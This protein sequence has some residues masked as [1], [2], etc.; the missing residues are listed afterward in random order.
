MSDNPPPTIGRVVT[1][2]NCPPNL[3]LASDKLWDANGMPSLDVLKDWF[4]KEGRLSTEDATKICEL[5]T[6]VLKEEPNV[7]TINAAVT[8]CGDIHG[9]FYDLVKLF[10]VGGSPSETTYIFLGDYVDRGQFGLEC[11]LFLLSHKIRYPKN[12]FLLRGN[13]ECRHLTAF[14]NFKEECLYKFNEDLYD[15]IMNAFD[16]LPL[17]A[18]VNQKFFCCHGGLSPE[19]HSVDQI[20]E[21]NR[22]CE[23]PNSGAMC[24]ILW[25]DPLDD[26]AEDTTFLPNS[27]RGCSVFFGVAAVARFL[28]ENNLLSV[29]RAHE[30]QLDGFKMH[31]KRHPNDFPSVI[32]LFSAPNY[33]DTYA[34]KGAI[35]KYHENT[36]KIRQFN[37]TP[38]PYYLPNFMNVFEWSLPFVADKI[39]EFCVAILN[40]TPDE[41]E[42]VP[43]AAEQREISA[44]VIKNKIRSAAKFAVMLRA[45]RDHSDEI[46]QIK[47]EMPDN[48][49]P[50]GLLQ[51]GTAEI[52]KVLESFNRAKLA[53]VNNE[54]LPS[55]EELKAHMAPRTRKASLGPDQAEKHRQQMQMAEEALANDSTK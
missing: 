25:A 27:T 7:L 23:P 44:R 54:R 15:T 40:R 9:Q 4:L 42:E 17:A 32:T 34:N 55:N 20:H 18:V 51:K 45:L 31:H 10:E 46:L 22:F 13:H 2:V 48:K 28:K 49:I 50:T 11:T 38:H 52:R 12:F 41:E 33:C 6:E 53:D 39:G 16:C 43:R 8:V 36:M 30:A 26:G 21:I 29:L 1:E 37:C 14:F 35:L 3:P 24:D 19:L 5:A 47:Q